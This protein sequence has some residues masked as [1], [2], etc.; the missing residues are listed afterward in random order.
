MQVIKAKKK[1]G[2]QMLVI[3]GVP[4]DDPVLPKVN[5]KYRQQTG[6]QVYKGGQGSAIW[7]TNSGWR[8]GREKERHRHRHMQH[9]RRGPGHFARCGEGA[10]GSCHRAASSRARKGHMRF[11][12]REATTRRQSPRSLYLPQG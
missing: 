12:E 9:A 8:A 5:G 7:H 2:A 6:K 3:K 10:M 4:T 11:S 1:K